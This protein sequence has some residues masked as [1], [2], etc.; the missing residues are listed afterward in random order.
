MVIPVFHLDACI[1]LWM[2]LLFGYAPE[3]TPVY[4]ALESIRQGPELFRANDVSGG[5]KMHQNC[6][7]E[8][9]PLKKGMTPPERGGTRSFSDLDPI[10]HA[11]A[12]AFDE[13]GLGMM[14][15]AVEQG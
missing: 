14:Q 8:N 9:A 3:I 1:P 2:G 15:E 5:M 6:R 12:F 13:D 4:D 10:L 7:F 11:I